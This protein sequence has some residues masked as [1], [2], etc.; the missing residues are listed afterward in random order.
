MKH[1]G[2]KI[3]V[4]GCFTVKGVGHIHHIKGVMGQNVFKQILIH[5][6]CPLLLQFG[7]KGH[8]I[9][10]HKMIQN[11][12]LNHWKII[13]NKLNTKSFKIGLHCHTLYPSNVWQELK[14]RFARARFWPRNKGKRFNIVKRE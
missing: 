8:I 13:S 9:F 6:I 2:G 12:Q 10:Q 11:T 3:Q 4:L 7:R 5:H 14:I 1:G